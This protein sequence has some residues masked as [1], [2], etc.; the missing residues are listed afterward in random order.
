MSQRT[1]GTLLAYAL[2]VVRIVVTLFYTPIL[3]GEL[4]QAAYGLFALVGALAAY[5]YVLDFG[6]ND[7]VLRFFVA[8]GDR[9]DVRDAFLARMLVLYLGIAG[10]VALALGGM[11][12]L[13]GPVFAR[14][15]APDQIET[16]R[17]M[18]VLTG[19]GAVALVAGNPVAALLSA[20][21][22]FVFLR[23]LE[24]AGVI[25]AALLNTWF[26]FQGFGAVAVVAVLTSTMLLQV[27][28]RV[29]YAVVVLGVRP[30][31]PRPDRAELGRVARYAAPI[32]VSMLAEVVFWRLDA[33]IIAALIGAAPVAIYAIGVTFKTYFMSFATAMSRA[34]TPEIVRRV[35]A[36]AGAAEITDLMVRI[37]R[38]QALVLFLI[39][40]AL[41]VFGLRFITLWLGPGY[42]QSYIVMLLVLGPYALELTGNARNIVLQVSGLYWRK[43]AITIA[44]ALLNVPLTILLIGPFGVIGAAASTSVAILVNYLLIARLLQ[45]ALGLDMARYWRGTAQGILPVFIAATLAFQLLEPLIPEGWFWLV[46]GCLIYTLAYATAA[47]RFAMNDQE[48]GR[49]I[50]LT[51][52]FHRTAAR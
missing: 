11:V 44:M 33:A 14:S 12:A 42:E 46:V 21:E 10:L 32:F 1:T 7:S 19:I 4:G 3:V 39:L 37:S 40:G 9:R 49:L 38:L 6:I 26:L 43:S 52:L 51:R 25:G 27:L 36:G 17:I 45:S 23:G 8:H 5:L 48:R 30:G 15:I 29:V 31:S 50:A 16:L 28:A 34:I 47:W 18:M 22:R 35:D 24:M 20:S 2:I 13:I 41:I